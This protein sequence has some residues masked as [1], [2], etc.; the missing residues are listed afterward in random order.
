MLQNSDGSETR[1]HSA[2][3]NFVYDEV[4]DTLTGT[5]TSISRTS[6]GG[7]DTFETIT[8]LNLSAFQLYEVIFIPAYIGLVFAGSDV[9]TGW[10]G[11]DYLY[12]GPDG[13]SFNGGDGS[14]F[15]DYIW[16]PT[17]VDVDLLTPANNGG[18]AA[19]DTYISIENV[20]GTVYADSISGDNNNNILWGGFG[21]DALNGRG[22]FDLAD[23]RSN[24]QNN[25]IGLTA[26]LSHPQFNTG[27]AFGDYYVSIEGLIGTER[28]DL[29]TGDAGN[30]QIRGEDGND[31]L[32]GASSNS[33]AMHLSD[34]SSTPIHRPTMAGVCWARR[35]PPVR[36]TNSGLKVFSLIPH[37]ARHRV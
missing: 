27:A 36:S 12:G 31:V 11:V 17:S 21:P 18:E 19:G 2:L 8:G 28:A 5:V 34:S 26:S 25:T 24:V 10:S 22:G 4:S 3:S 35:P 16:A 9:V 20:R 1:L 29:L 14:D 6:S 13:D 33:V 23:Y 30:N 15:V 37:Q 7:G 32:R